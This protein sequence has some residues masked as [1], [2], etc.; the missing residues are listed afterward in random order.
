MQIKKKGN[1]KSALLY[2]CETWKVTNKIIDSLQAFINKCLRR[3][4][5]IFWPT[6]VTNENYAN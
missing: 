3:I 6:V 1:V 5:H 4:L 2:G